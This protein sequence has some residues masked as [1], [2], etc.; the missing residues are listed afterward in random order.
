MSVEQYMRAV[1]PDERYAGH[2]HDLAGAANRGAAGIASTQTLLVDVQ[3]SGQLIKCFR[4]TD[5]LP[6]KTVTQ[7]RVLTNLPPALPD[8]SCA[9]PGGKRQA[10]HESEACNP[11]GGSDG[12]PVTQI[13]L[14]PCAGSEH[15]API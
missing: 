11:P 3:P 5:G 4:G 8:G 6:S 15:A 12:V 13:D 14:L 9:A 7:V 1:H 2:H 10:R